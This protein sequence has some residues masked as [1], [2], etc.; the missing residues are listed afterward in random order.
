MELT[1]LDLSI[2]MQEFGQLEEGFVQKV[3]QRGDELTLEIYVPGDEKKR[4]VIGTSHAFISDYKRDNPER[5]PGF[6]MELRKHLGRV[7]S[8]SQRGFDRILEIESGEKTLICEIFGKGNFILLDENRIIGALRQEEYADRSVIVGE[9]YD[10]PEPANDPRELDDY[11]DLME[12]ELVRRLASDLSL[13]GTY[14]EEI[15]SRAGIEKDIE[16][17]EMT[18][19]QKDRV[20]EELEKMFK[21]A[22]NP[23]PRL[24]IE[25]LPERPSPFTL[26]TYSDFEEEEFESFSRA[27]DEYFYRRKSRQE[28]Q[29]KMEAYRE[30]KQGLERQLEQQERKKE[31]LEKSSEQNRRKAELIYENYQLLEKIQREIA[32]SIEQNGWDET[33]KRL[34]ESDG[35]LAERVNAMNQQEEFISVE[36]EDRNIKLTVDEDLEAIASRYYDKAK[37]SE[38]KIESVEKAMEE[39]RE[40]IDELEQDEV[41]VEESMEDKSSKRSKKWFEKYRWFRSSEGYLVLTGRDAQTNDMLVKKHMDSSDLYLHADFDGAPSLVVKDGQEAGEETLQEAAKAAVTFSKTWKAGIGADDVY[42]V[43]PDQVTEN[44]ESGEYL[45]KGAFVIRGDRNYIRN[46][47]VEAAVGPYEIEEDLFV[48]VCGPKTAIQKN[49]PAMIELEPGRT[50]KSKLAKQI[51]QK[52]RE[53]SFNCDLDYIVRSLPPGKSD[54]K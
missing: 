29:K 52:F 14:A 40:K 22:E 36:V 21:Q 13:G 20:H 46:V 26:E 51:Q 28:E 34:K 25:D 19:E 27:M 1:S 41:E 18:E 4:L 32:E 10:Y 54:I 45:E 11:F 37:E 31:G 16:I 53:Q 39:T 50:K 9:E 42:H 43:E 8:I 3:Y 33:E 23:D 48:P 15:C 44:P 49:C 35:E 24:Y 30:K 47:S 5:P 6:C 17:A 2:L 12:G 7:D 38:S